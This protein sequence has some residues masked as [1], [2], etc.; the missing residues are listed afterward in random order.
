MNRFTCGI[1]SMRNATMTV[2]APC[3]G[4]VVGLSVT[5]NESYPVGAVL[6][7]LLLGHWHKVGRISLSRGV[8]AVWVL[9]A[10]MAR[11]AMTG[12]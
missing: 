9:A 11:H 7:H 10:L 6:G 8:V 4:Q 2:T 1:C 5:L 3:G 12:F